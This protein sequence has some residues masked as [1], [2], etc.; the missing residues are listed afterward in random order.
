MIEIGLPLFVR[1]YVEN[2]ANLPFLQWT[3]TMVKNV[4]GLHIPFCC[5]STA[6]SYRGGYPANVPKYSAYTSIARKTICSCAHRVLSSPPPLCSFQQIYR[7]SLR[8]GLVTLHPKHSATGIQTPSFATP[9]PSASISTPT[10]QFRWG[11][12][13]WI[14]RECRGVV[15]VVYRFLGLCSSRDEDGRKWGCLKWEKDMTARLGCGLASKRI[16]HA[17]LGPT[18][19][20]SFWRAACVPSSRVSSGGYTTMPRWNEIPYSFQASCLDIQSVVV[21]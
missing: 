1:V 10:T 13:I 21:L 12:R 5:W 14:R 11:R 9:Q 16:A 4:A 2:A 20:K 3:R 19:C 8:L 6:A 7:V 17:V 18:S 15:I